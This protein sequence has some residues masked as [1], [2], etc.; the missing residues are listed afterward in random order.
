MNDRISKLV[1]N[2]PDPLF[3]KTINLVC[4]SGAFNG[5]YLYGGLLYLKE[6][7]KK[8]IISINK[9]SGSS[10][11]SLFSF[12]YLIDELDKSEKYYEIIRNG[13]KEN[14]CLSS[15]KDSL[16]SMLE[17]FPDN[18]YTK[19]NNRL[20]INYYNIQTN[21]EEIKST[22]L[23]NEEIIETIIS[24]S[25]IPYLMDG[26]LCYKGRI[27]GCN[28][29][30]F[31]KR[32]IDDDKILFI[33][34]TSFSKLK[35]MMHIKGEY[36]NSERL[37]EGALD[38]HKFF[39]GEKSLLC[40][41]VNNWTL[42]DYCVFRGRQLFWFSVVFTC[43]IIHKIKPYI[44]GIITDNRIYY[45]IKSVVSNTYQDLFVIFYNS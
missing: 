35:K 30:I 28:P 6:L 5:S 15:F 17:I 10:I 34:L 29:Y 18:I 14:F 42:F 9:I 19:V 44:P 36:N 43:Y 21:K 27:D 11:G 26:T 37:L 33:R 12:L 23:S 22:F 31:K 13:F 41:W 1:D 4:D 7:E 39:K 20:Y 24:S 40:S 45:I 3:T 8:R 38:L 2:L 16:Y 32:T 25:F